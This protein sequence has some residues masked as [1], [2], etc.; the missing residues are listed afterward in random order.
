MIALFLVIVVA[1]LGVFAIRI[2]GT[3]QQTATLQLLGFQTEAAA[4]A[5]LEAW[6]HAVFTA[7]PACPGVGTPGPLINIG[8]Y[9]NT[10]LSGFTVRLDA[11]TR[12]ASGTNWVYDIRVSAERGTYGQPDFVRRVVSRRMSNIGSGSYR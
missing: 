2:G 4:N 5:G 8:S 1:A 6:A 9:P 7:A 11:C 3:Q 12:I 10:G